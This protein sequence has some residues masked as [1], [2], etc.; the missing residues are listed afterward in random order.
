MRTNRQRLFDMGVDVSDIEALFNADDAGICGT[1]DAQIEKS[2]SP[3]NPACEGKWCEQAIAIYLDEEVTED[4]NGS[5]D[6]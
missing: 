4:N 2:L 6:M 5:Q 1:C 3:S